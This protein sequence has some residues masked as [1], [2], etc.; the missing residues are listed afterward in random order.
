M[1]NE[2]VV[3][4]AVR[5]PESHLSPRWRGGIIPPVCT[6]LDRD[7]EVDT[8]SLERHLRFL[9]EAGVSGLFMLG[10]SGEVAF[11][12]DAQ[13]DAVLR[14]AVKVS[15]GQVPELAGAIDMTTRRVVDHALRAKQLGV[16]AIVITAPFYAQVTHPAEMKLHFRVVRDQVCLPLVAYDIPV[17]VHTKLERDV[18]KELAEEGVIEGVKDSS[19]DMGGLRALLAGTRHLER[20][21][22]LTGSEVLV[23]CALF[24]GAAGAVAGLANVDPHS[25]VELYHR[26]VSGDWDGARK[27]QDRL[28]RLSEVIRCADVTNKGLSSSITGGYKT[29][30][31]LRGIIANNTVGLPQIALDADESAA[32]RAVL[33]REGLL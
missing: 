24:F 1:T 7:G 28:V 10:S 2:H 14:V 33:Q 27:I 3:Y 4:D 17:A 29:A 16:D 32:V 8:Q 25:Y 6:P 23:D 30:L 12:T 18:V 5:P 15:G 26:C 20:F 9:I 11:L 13:R 22:V 21:S 31:V 19:M